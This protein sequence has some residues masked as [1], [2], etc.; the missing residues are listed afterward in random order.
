MI[1]GHIYIESAFSAM[2]RA[3]AQV[4]FS[5]ILLNQR[6]NTPM[7]IE[8]SK[9]SLESNRWLE[10]VPLLLCTRESTRGKNVLS[11][12]STVG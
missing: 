1:W 6:V 8:G 9:V 11:K 4:S 10:Q 3:M 2:R 12:C 5:R 7:V